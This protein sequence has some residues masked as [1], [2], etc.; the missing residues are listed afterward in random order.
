MELSSE[1]IVRLIERVSGIPEL[2]N[3][4]GELEELIMKFKKVEEYLVRFESLEELTRHLKEIEDKIYLCKTYLTTNEA[5]SYVAMS[6][7][8]LLEAAKRRDLPFYT[9][10]SKC[11]YFT[12][13]ELDK[14]I[15]GFRVPS[16]QEMLEESED[17]TEDIMKAM[18]NIRAL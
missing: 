10:P 3:K 11:F 7:F 1:E 17:S 13:E 14:W 6:K 16:K 4:K 8:T 2:L 5:S 9:P 12:K 18:R 15:N